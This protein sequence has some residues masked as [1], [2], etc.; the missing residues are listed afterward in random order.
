MCVCVCFRFY[1]FVYNLETKHFACNGT[2]GVHW[3]TQVVNFYCFWALDDRRED[4]QKMDKKRS[5]LL[6]VVLLVL[7]LWH[8]AVDGFFSNLCLSLTFNQQTTDYSRDISLNL[9]VDLSLHIA[10]TKSSLHNFP[11]LAERT[12]LFMLI[13]GNF[14][15]NRLFKC[16]SNHQQH[17]HHHHH[18]YQTDRII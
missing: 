2:L 3:Q 17:Q 14:A 1:L 11:W 8:P 7:V 4:K 16:A 12:L 9:W 5:W 18:P 10:V 13:C 6:L 15:V